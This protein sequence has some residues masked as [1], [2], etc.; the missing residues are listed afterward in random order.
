MKMTY[1]KCRLKAIINTNFILL[2]WVTMV[3]KTQAQ[4]YPNLEPTPSKIFD[5]YDVLLRSLR[6]P[7][8]SL[9]TQIALICL[10]CWVHISV[11]LVLA[12]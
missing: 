6:G 7:S 8:V 1:G 2:L 4:G 11:G 5:V 12:L 10:K 3:R 9:K